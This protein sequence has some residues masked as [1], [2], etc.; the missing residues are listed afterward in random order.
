MLIRGAVV[1]WPLSY[2]VPETS[3][4]GP[5]RH[6]C[7]WTSTLDPRSASSP[8][9]L[10]PRPPVQLSHIYT[11]GEEDVKQGTIRSLR[12]WGG[13]SPAPAHLLRNH[14]SLTCLDIHNCCRELGTPYA[15]RDPHNGAT[16]SPLPRSAHDVPACSSLLKLPQLER[17]QKGLGGHHRG[18]EWPVCSVGHAEKT[19]KSPIARLLSWYLLIAYT[20]TAAEVWRPRNCPR[21]VI[22]PLRCQRCRMWSRV[23]VWQAGRG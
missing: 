13:T 21:C 12:N 20:A 3:G 23:C 19:R 1:V 2:G 14:A 8:S 16:L 9:F 5:K 18:V 11:M 22:G 4:H 6:P 15:P 10:Y 7:L 17:V